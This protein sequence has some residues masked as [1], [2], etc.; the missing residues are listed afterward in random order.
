MRKLRSFLFLGLASLT[1]A[2]CDLSSMMGGFSFPGM[3]D[4]ENNLTSSKEHSSLTNE[5]S[6]WREQHSSMPRV[7]VSPE[8]EKQL[9]EFYDAYMKNGGYLSFEDWLINIQYPEQFGIN[10]VEITKE[11]E[12]FIYYNDG[13]VETIGHSW[14]YD[15]TLTSGNCTQDDESLYRCDECGLYKIITTPG[16][17][18]H[19]F[20]NTYVVVEPT[21]VS[22]GMTRGYCVNCGQE[23]YTSIPASGHDFVTD[24]YSVEG[25]FTCDYIG[26]YEEECRNCGQRRTLTKQSAGHDLYDINGYPS[27]GDFS[28]D[29]Y[30]DAGYIFSNCYKDEYSLY[31]WN[32]ELVTKRCI[33]PKNVYV[34]TDPYSDTMGYQ[35]EPN[36]VFENDGGVSFY[37]R[38]KNNAQYL[39]Y[40]GSAS[41]GDHIG[42]YDENIEGSFLEYKVNLRQDLYNVRLTSYLKPAPYLGMSGVDV[43]KAR[44]GDTEWTEGY[45]VDENGDILRHEF[46]VLFY[47]DGEEVALDSEV[48]TLVTD[49]NLYNKPAWYSVPMER[50]NLSSGEH[51]IKLVMAGGWRHTFYQ[52][53]FETEALPSA[54]PGIRHEHD[55]SNVNVQ[56]KLP[57]NALR[58]LTASC[59]C[60]K[61]I[62]GYEIL[63]QDVEYGQANPAESGQGTPEKNTR[64]GRNNIF[65]DVWNV[66]G[67]EPGDY[68]VYIKGRCSAGNSNAGYWNSA[69]AIANG[70]S[71]ANNG[72]STDYKYKITTTYG[73]PD[74]SAEWINLGNDEDNYAATGLNENT[75]AWTNKP[76]ATIQFDGVADHLTIKNM[77]SGYSIWVYAVRL[78]KRPHDHLF[79]NETFVN[80]E[81]PYTK[82]SC[83][84]NDGGVALKWNSLDYSELNGINKFESEP[85]AF[86]LRSNGDYISYNINCQK[87]VRGRL[88]FLAAMD[89]WGENTMYADYN[90]MS[91]KNNEVGL[92]FQIKSNSRTIAVDERQA[93]KPYGELIPTRNAN[94]NGIS[95]YFWIE[96]GDIQLIAGSNTIQYQRIDS[97]NLVIKAWKV[98]GTEIDA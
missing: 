29:G 33:T 38:A 5:E 79:G 82:S 24:P 96:L 23:I 13:H 26:D 34:K 28:G 37:G 97:Y 10:N 84:S 78:V 53:G 40:T 49:R 35:E 63:A 57:E 80:G 25:G 8:M 98:I 45:Y 59:R 70:G 89:C 14:R 19:Y 69:T 66:N 32:A 68:D 75:P 41:D 90:M 18:K 12:I 77:N 1:L 22:E 81:T 7:S 55:Y 58:P 65:E 94:E 50:I 85:D 95:D 86:K 72:N 6:S 16:T 30:S 31:S 21:C 91:R 67:I 44:P 76:L 4:L 87:E 48:D 56:N 46:R 2:S 74:E 27:I 51:T 73:Q 36:C 15:R 17:G 9:L 64:L 71:A 43:W 47:I 11:G 39:D 60:G 3:D 83:V 52:F 42:V 93:T 61:G 20:G 62:E 92:N 88:W 54:N